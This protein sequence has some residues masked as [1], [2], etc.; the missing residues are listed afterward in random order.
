MVNG[1]LLDC[2]ISNQYLWTS[3]RTKM[4]HIM[5]ARIRSISEQRLEQGH[6]PTLFLP[7]VHLAGAIKRRQWKEKMVIGAAGHRGDRLNMD[8]RHTRAWGHR[9]PLSL[10]RPTPHRC[11]RWL[12][13]LLESPRSAKAAAGDD[14]AHVADGDMCGRS[15]MSS[16]LSQPHL[17]TQHS[18]ISIAN[19]M[20]TNSE[21]KVERKPFWSPPLF[22]GRQGMSTARC[23]S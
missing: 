11:P 23:A 20:N 5:Q 17:H 19:N 16:A 6:I 10:R 15:A 8:L 13:A 1:L 2:K 12:Q 3:V 21:T 22:L 14:V 18:C 7:E 9:F 4:R